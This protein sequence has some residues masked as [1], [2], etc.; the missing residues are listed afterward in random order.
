[1]HETIGPDQATFCGPDESC[2]SMPTGTLAAPTHIYLKRSTVPA[3]NYVEPRS[4]MFEFGPANVSLSKEV[5]VRI[6]IS[7]SNPTTNISIYW[8]PSEDGIFAPLTGTCGGDFCNASVS[9]LG[10]FIAG[11]AK[12]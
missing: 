7:P 10:F 6:R 9:A 4:L 2:V 1:M 12:S 11:R 3:P 5:T 8:S